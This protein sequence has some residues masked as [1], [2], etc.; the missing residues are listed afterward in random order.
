VKTTKYL[1]MHTSDY[2]HIESDEERVDRYGPDGLYPIQ[3]YEMFQ[4]GRYQVLNKIGF[5]GFSTIWV[6][7]DN[8]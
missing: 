6:A 7:Q 8:L 3:L 2:C 5:G 4:D 1:N